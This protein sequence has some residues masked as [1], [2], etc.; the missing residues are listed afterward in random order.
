LFELTKVVVFCVSTNII[1]TTVVD[2]SELVFT[3]FGRQCVD[4]S[5]M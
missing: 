2:I 4:A 5:Y 1:L 3:P